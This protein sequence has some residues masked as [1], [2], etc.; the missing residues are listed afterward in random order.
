[1]PAV[2][3]KASKAWKT[4]LRLGGPVCRLTNGPRAADATQNHAG[5][6]LVGVSGGAVTMLV[7]SHNNLAP[8]PTLRWR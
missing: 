3:S 1:M 8:A 5:R 4:G 7:L 6:M 2:P